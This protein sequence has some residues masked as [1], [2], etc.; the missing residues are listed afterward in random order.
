MSQVL[1]LCTKTLLALAL[2]AFSALPLQAA[3]VDQVVSPGGI[4]AWLIQDHSNP[5][6][7]VHLAFRGGASLDPEGKAGLASMV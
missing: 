5:I 4:K 6:I 7:S 1:R 2:V 3:P